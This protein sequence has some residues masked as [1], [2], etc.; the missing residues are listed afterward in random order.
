MRGRRISLSVQMAAMGLLAVAGAGCCHRMG[1]AVVA[2]EPAACDGETEAVCQPECARPCGFWRGLGWRL[3][4][5][6]GTAAGTTN[7]AEPEPDIPYA[8]L[9]PV[10]TRPVFGPEAAEETAG[11][12]DPNPLPRLNSPSEVPGESAAPSEEMAPSPSGADNSSAVTPRRLASSAPRASW[13][14]LP[15]EPQPLGSAR[16][17]QRSPHVGP[18][19]R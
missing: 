16:Q 15:P 14:F 5:K 9:H 13:I 6:S 11:I 4:G 3:W 10:P 2:E 18:T 1:C 8:R 19:P 7:Q 17:A 12:A